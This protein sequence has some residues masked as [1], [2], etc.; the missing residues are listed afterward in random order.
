MTANQHGPHGPATHRAGKVARGST[1]TLIAT[2]L[3]SSLSF[4]DGSVVNVALPAIG[5]D[6]GAGAGAVQWIVNAY[7]LPLSALVLLGGALSDRFG[8]KRLFLGGVALF[9]LAS[10]GSVVAPN[11]D[12]LHASRALQGL[13]A[14]LFVPASLAILGTDFE[15]AARGRAIGTWAAA[16]AIAGA[17]GPI[18]GG[19]LVD[20][21]GWRAIFAINVPIAL[22]AFVMGWRSIAPSRA[23]DT[24]ADA[25]VDWTGAILATLALGAMTWGLTRLSDQGTHSGAIALGIA[26]LFGVGFWFVERGAGDKAMVPFALFGTRTFSGI[27][28]LTLLLYGALAAIMLLLPY[29]LISHGW[30]ASE[31]GATLLPASI[32]MGLGS[33]FAGRL[34][35]R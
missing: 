16:G 18:L 23:D 31:A 21:V 9:A 1:A 20:T 2:V 6:L 25:P 35:E 22:A 14:A 15:G 29:L 33:R 3:G 34:A 11:I 32:L 5:R 12:L 27:T 24:G 7:L 13:G 26:A 8:R 30:P 19:V 4:I 17:A 28:I 10:L